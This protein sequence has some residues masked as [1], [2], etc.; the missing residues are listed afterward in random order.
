MTDNYDVDVVRNLIQ[1]Q[2]MQLIEK[3][4]KIIFLYFKE[5]REIGQFQAFCG[6]QDRL[7]QIM[8][9]VRF[10]TLLRIKQRKQKS[11]KKWKDNKGSNE[12]VP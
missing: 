2:I 11:D 8:K 7:T 10:I 12:R 1:S 4:F 6:T 5:I 3:K 9:H